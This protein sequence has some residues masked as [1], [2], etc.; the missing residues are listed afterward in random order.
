MT[1]QIPDS[2]PRLRCLK[3]SNSTSLAESTSDAIIGTPTIVPRKEFS[4]TERRELG[5]IGDS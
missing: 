1:P 5:R 2:R 3:I 4:T